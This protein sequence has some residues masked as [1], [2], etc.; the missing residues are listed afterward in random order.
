MKLH[1][2][3]FN[4]VYS[5]ATKSKFLRDMAEFVKEKCCFPGTWT[6]AHVER[7]IRKKYKPEHIAG[8]IAIV[9]NKSSM[10]AAH[11]ENLFPCLSPVEYDIVFMGPRSELEVRDRAYAEK[12]NCTVISANEVIRRKL[13][14]KLAVTMWG[15]H[16]SKNSI[17]KKYG[18]SFIA[19]KTLLIASIYDCTYGIEYLEKFPYDYV[20][21]CGEFGRKLFETFGRKDNIFVLGSPRFTPKPAASDKE[22]RTET[23]RRMITEQTGENINPCKKTILLLASYHSA[24]SSLQNCASIDFL[25][26]LKKPQDEYNIIIK[27]H[28]EWSSS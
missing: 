15:D 18:L 4:A 17:I 26:M 20:V 28:P 14:Y 9:I 12:Y 11:L 21:C 8:K 10:S 27:P 13:C 24:I 23:A 19:E 1:I 6:N 25:P 2:C 16:K 3:V 7:L 22:D 5:V